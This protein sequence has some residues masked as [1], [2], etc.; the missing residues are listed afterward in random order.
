MILKR[1]LWVIAAVLACSG[2]GS[3]GTVPQ[4]RIEV[5]EVEVMGNVWVPLRQALPL[6]GSNPVT[7][8]LG[9]FSFHQG[10]MDFR[11][12]SQYFMM[13]NQ[14]I[15]MG[16][17]CLNWNGE[18][19]IHRNDWE[20][21]LQPLLTMEPVFEDIHRR[22]VIDAGHGG[23][24]TG[25]MNQDRTLME[26]DLTLDMAQRLK[27]LLE[28]AGWQVFLT[29]NADITLDLEPRI[30]IARDFNPDFF[31]SLHVN[32]AAAVEASG[33][34]TF[35]TTP[36]GLPSNLKRG[37][38]DPI[39]AVYPANSWDEQS[40]QLAWKI[41]RHLL[42]ATGAPD[43]GI[44]MARFMGVIRNQACPAILIETGFISN[45]DECRHLASESYRQKIAQGIADAFPARMHL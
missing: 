33:I 26:K 9:S 27:T 38:E 36:S 24:D 3:R 6:Y 28:A 16:Y 12:D 4:S 5:P 19:M 37:Y 20:K 10:T 14:K 34:E 25:A 30:G 7:D 17:P 15:W 11:P 45:P 21:N 18:L 1:A 41:Q 44:K 32:S 2:C 22:V 42:I 8:S 31:I 13:V 23:R 43:R 39:D 29:R 35:L 40:F